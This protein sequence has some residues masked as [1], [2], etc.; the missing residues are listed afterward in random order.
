MPLSDF[1][2]FV[3]PEPTE[4]AE[5]ESH[6]PVRTTLSL[7]GGKYKVFIL[8]SLFEGTQRFSQLQ[9]AIPQANSKMLSQQLKELECDG[10]IVRKAYPVIPPKVEYS[11]TP[12]G[13]SIKPVLRCIYAWGT[14]YLGARGSE[15]CCSMKP[16]AEDVCANDGDCRPGCCGR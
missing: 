9:K 3:P 13:M 11:L 16:F 8:W 6:C 14:E 15:A 1:D 5:P 2:A 12:L 7:I 10:L 4:T